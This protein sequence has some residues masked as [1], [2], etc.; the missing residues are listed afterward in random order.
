MQFSHTPSIIVLV[1]F[2]AAYAGEDFESARKSVIT[3]LHKEQPACI[4]EFNTFFKRYDALV[5]NFFDKKNNEPLTTHICH[6]ET[7]LQTLKTV[8]NDTRYGCIN[9][10]LC[11]YQ[12]HIEDLISLLKSYVGSHDSLS[13]AFKVRKFKMILP[14][15]VKKRGDISLFWSLHHRLRC[16]EG[17]D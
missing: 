1:F 7:E 5:V 17:S 14:E 9:A 15:H 8:C 16:E 2:S 3:C 12:T 11:T 13:L 6:M 4:A 10:I